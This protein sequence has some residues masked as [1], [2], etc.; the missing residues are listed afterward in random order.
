MIVHSSSK[1]LMQGLSPRG[2][3]VMPVGKQHGANLFCRKAQFLQGKAHIAPP[4]IHARI[5]ENDSCGRADNIG[6]GKIRYTTHTP[7][8]RSHWKH[9]RLEHPGLAFKFCFRVAFSA[10]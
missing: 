9:L 4:R 5:H 6:A 8:G 3:V 10:T 7:D 2:V 1:L